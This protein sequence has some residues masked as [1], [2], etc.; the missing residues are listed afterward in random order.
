MSCSLKNWKKKTKKQ[1]KPVC[2]SHWELLPSE[3]QLPGTLNNCPKRWWSWRRRSLA[4]KPLIGYGFEVVCL[5]P[6]KIPALQGGRGINSRSRLMKSWIFK[7]TFTKNDERGSFNGI[8]NDSPGRKCQAG[9]FFFL[10][11][12]SSSSLL[13]PTLPNPPTHT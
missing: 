1:K 5:E 11:F 9:Y 12:L 2:C 10:D 13:S 7:L 8:T 4:S 3:A 6:F